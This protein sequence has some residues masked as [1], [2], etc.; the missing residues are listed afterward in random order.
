MQDTITKDEVYQMII[1]GECGV[2][3]PKILECFKMAKIEFEKLVDQQHNYIE[4]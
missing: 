1:N 3:S 4:E 2:F